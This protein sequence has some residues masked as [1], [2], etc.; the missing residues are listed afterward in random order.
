MEFSAKF[1]PDRPVQ[2]NCIALQ[3]SCLL[4]FALPLW[5]NEDI[6]WRHEDQLKRLGMYP[7]IFR[8]GTQSSPIFQVIERKPQDWGEPIY[9][10]NS[11]SQDDSRPI[12]NTINNWQQ[13]LDGANAYRHEEEEYE[14]LL[15]ERLWEI[16]QETADIVWSW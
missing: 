6:F 15:D 1:L 4:H 11:Y 14:K 3:L 16:E 13:S 8:Y 12:F 5:Y 7:R 9:W 2:A 10:S